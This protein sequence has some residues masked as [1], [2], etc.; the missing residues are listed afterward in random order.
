MTLELRPYQREMVDF[1]LEHKRC[2][3][4]SFMGSGK[5]VSVLTAIDYLRF[6]GEETKP[7]LILGPL[8]VIQTVWNG[9][10]EKWSHLRHLKVSV[11]TGSESQR[12]HAL[13]QKADIYCI[14]YE[15]IEWLMLQ[16]DDR[17]P[18]GYVIADESTK[19]K[20]YRSK[21]GGVRA[22]ALSNI[23]SK[24]T[25]WINLTGTPTPR[26]L[27]CLWGQTWFLDQGQRLGRTYDSFKQRWF[28]QSFDGYGLVP[29]PFAQKQMEEKLN[30]I[31]MSLDPKDHFDL[32]EPIVNKIYV[33]LPAPAAKLYK[34]MEKKMF[35][36]IA[37]NPI[38]AFN[39]A[40]RT[41]KCLQLCNG[42]AYL[43]NDV[44]DDKTPKKWKEVH[45][46]KLDALE[47][48]IAESGGMPVLVAYNFRSDLERLKKAFPKGRVLDK[49]PD[50]IRDWNIGKI[51]LL[52]AHPAS[53]GHGLNLQDG[54]NILVF[55]GVNWNLEEHLQIIE[56]IG[57]V[58]Q[59]QA[60]YDRPVFIHYILARKTVDELVMERLKTKKSVQ[61]ILLEALKNRGSSPSGT[62]ETDSQ[63]LV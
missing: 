14:N 6:L 29:H 36:E 22:R 18:F 27:D 13:N 59:L 4:F 10:I 5:S 52:F 53:A 3:L 20:S 55:F 58:R 54:G 33:E 44:E 40:A 28:G 23:A 63:E 47:E 24:C 9:E 25:G 50:T 46:V 48:I 1:I 32:K 30:D 51:P 42:A 19:L 21:Q 7:V 37:G 34:D 2:A 15:N 26:G 31:C 39:A 12:R 17:W 45:K 35:M 41:N 8:R 11:I 62:E 56:R 57:P 38:E 60:G 61:D 49:N 16:L 43:D